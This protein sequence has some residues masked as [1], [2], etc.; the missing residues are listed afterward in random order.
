MCELRSRTLWTQI[1]VLVF[2]SKNGVRYFDF[3]KKKFKDNV[4][5]F[6]VGTE[7]E[8][9]TNT[10]DHIAYCFTSI[11]GYSKF[12]SYVGNGVAS[13]GGPFIYL[14]FKPAFF[15]L[16]ETSNADNWI[17]LDNRRLGYNKLI[18][19]LFPNLANAEYASDRVELRSN[20]VK[21]IDNDGSVNTSGA[22]YI[23]MSFAENPFV[24]NDS[25]TSIPT[26]G[27]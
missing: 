22:T 19:H 20:G 14:G 18:Y 27:F 11:K 5:V 15:M 17:I 8:V 1:D 21:V 2:T 4:L 23:Y 9:N 24:A 26:T 16:K 6:S 25:G 12:G 3:E 10:E 7:A 13:G